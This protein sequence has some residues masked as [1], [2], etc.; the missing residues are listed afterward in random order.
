MKI[1]TS[2][3]KK[4]RRS[5]FIETA[6]LSLLLTSLYYSNSGRQKAILQQSSDYRASFPSS[7]NQAA[8]QQF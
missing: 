7:Q 8:S 6:L 2:K 4:N 5:A 3:I 1:K